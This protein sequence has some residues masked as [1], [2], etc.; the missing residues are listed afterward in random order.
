MQNAELDLDALGRSLPERYRS[1]PGNRFNV[2]TAC[3]PIAHCLPNAVCA[4]ILWRFDR[5]GEG[6]NN[7][8]IAISACSSILPSQSA[9]FRSTTAARFVSFRCRRVSRNTHERW[10]PTSSTQR[11]GTLIR[12]SLKAPPMTAVHPAYVDNIVEVVEGYDAGADESEDHL[13]TE[14]FIDLKQANT[15]VAKLKTAEAVK[16]LKDN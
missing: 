9:A 10:R 5:L 11:C 1:V 12:F 4:Q 7:P 8:Y 13:F 2:L 6:Y 3:A 15:K 16:I 14:V